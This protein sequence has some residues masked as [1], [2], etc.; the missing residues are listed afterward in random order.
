MKLLHIERCK[1]NLENIRLEL[2]PVEVFS[3]VLRNILYCI[4]RKDQDIAR[5]VNVS[6][7][8]LSQWKNN[9]RLPDVQTLFCLGRE[10]NLKPY[11]T[12]SLVV[13]LNTHIA[14]QNVCDYIQ[15]VENELEY[16]SCKEE[17]EIES[18]YKNHLGTIEN[19]LLQYRSALE[20]V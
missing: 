5:S 18:W 6:P 12:R 3:D 20:T 1:Q 2:E 7:A 9:K 19:L 15:A 8:A 13:A 4:R 14:L 16:M 17:Q 11:Q 10:L